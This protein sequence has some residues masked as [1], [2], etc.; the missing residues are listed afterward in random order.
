VCRELADLA[1]FAIN[2][3]SPIEDVRADGASLVVETTAGERFRL[4]VTME[5]RVGDP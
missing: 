3:H 2:A 5:G 4:D 1:G